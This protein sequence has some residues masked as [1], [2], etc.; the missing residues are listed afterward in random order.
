MD[1]PVHGLQILCKQVPKLHAFHLRSLLIKLGYPL[2][3]AQGVP[4][5]NNW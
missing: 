4:E 3:P 1:I 2:V 5:V